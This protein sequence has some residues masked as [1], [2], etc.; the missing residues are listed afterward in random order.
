MNSIV[1]SNVRALQRCQGSSAR[2]IRRSANS[3]Q[4]HQAIDRPDLCR[5]YRDLRRLLSTKRRDDL[6]AKAQNLFGLSG[7]A[8]WAEF[9]ACPARQD[10][11]MQV[12]D[13]LPA[14]S[15]VELDDADPFCI[16]SFFGG[17]GDFLDP[18]HEFAQNRGI[19]IENIARGALWNDQDVAVCAWHDVHEGERNIIFIDFVA[20]QLAAQDFCKG[21]GAVV[22]CRHAAIH[23]RASEMDRRRVR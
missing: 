21:V 14:G 23:R 13:H 22:G 17:A 12:E 7:N 9:D 8:R 11:K 1:R 5:K 2:V 19:D 10:V 20:R 3:L 6:V 15:F 4:S 18:F 16:E